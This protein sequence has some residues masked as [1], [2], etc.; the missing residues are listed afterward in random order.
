MYA[1]E[2][3]RQFFFDLKTRKLRVFLAVSGITWGTL[4]VILLLAIGNA[5]QRASSKAMHGMGDDIVIM[6]TTQTTKPYAGMKPGRAIAL[7][8]D[9]VL[10]MGRDVPE[11]ASLSPELTF[12]GRTLKVGD[13]RVAAPV[14]GVVPEYEIM[15][16]M[17]PVPG[18]RFIDPLDV[19]YR[20]RV[21]YL[22]NEVREKL[23]SDQEAVGQTVFVDGRPFTVVGT[24]AKKIQTSNY[25][26]PDSDRAFIPYS[27][28][29][30]I[31]GNWDVSNTLLVPAIDGDAEPMKRAIY[32]YLGDKHRF[33]PTDEGALMMWDTVEMDKFM[34]W[35]F[36]GLQALMGLGGVLTLGAGGIGVANIMFLIV[37]ERTREIGVRMAVGAKDW[38][39]MGQ[40]LLEAVLIVGLGG[41]GGFL[42]SAG[43]IGI[44]GLIDLPDW[45]A[46]PALPP[47]VA[48]VTIAILALVG[49]TAGLF[50]ARRASRLD[51]VQALEF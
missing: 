8:A 19:Q 3:I 36:W 47:V 4:S 30:A 11:I 5:F 34:T 15:R 6:W 20:R 18:G 25:S 13:H 14:A 17:V 39:I 10:Q 41:A 42:I 51:P 27:T 22:G 44:L 46:Q 49:L 21:I 16:N 26:G 29:I 12:G 50:P 43:V 48:V 32:R 31:W 37:R 1:W 7:K 40:V 24:L 28:F 35:F 2:L 33:D 38:H 9:D 23:F 45:I